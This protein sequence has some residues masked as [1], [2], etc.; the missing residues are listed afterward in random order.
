MRHDG[1]DLLPSEPDVIG[2]VG[3]PGPFFE[4]DLSFNRIHR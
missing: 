4:L 2:R 3:W 1:F